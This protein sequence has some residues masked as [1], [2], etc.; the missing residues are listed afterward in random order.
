MKKRIREI[1]IAIASFAFFV[2]FLE[3][4][5]FAFDKFSIRFPAPLGAMIAFFLLLLTGI[6]PAKYVER[7]C[8][9]LTKNMMFYFIPFVVGIMSYKEMLR[10]KILQMGLALLLGVIVTMAITAFA[11]RIPDLFSGDAKA[12]G[13][14]DV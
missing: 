10:G 7:T 11:V 3:L 2:A 4:F 13:N 12:K 9:I 6:V 8:A 5:K 1:A 14:R